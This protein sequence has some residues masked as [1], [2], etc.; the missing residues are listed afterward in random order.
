M[1]LGLPPDDAGHTG[2]R[3]GD[4]PAVTVPDAT[5]DFL[6]ERH[7]EEHELALWVREVI[8]G[9]EP[10]LTERVYPG[11][12]GIG[13]RHPDAGYVCAIYPRDGAVRLLFEHGRRLDDPSGLLE[14]QGAQTRHVVV[15]ARDADLARDLAE[16]VSDAVAERLFRR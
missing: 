1:A 16:L 4:D 6:S 7:P 2:R 14:G 13:F 8:L 5:R 12:D 10:D 3:I 9:A 11:W 15:R